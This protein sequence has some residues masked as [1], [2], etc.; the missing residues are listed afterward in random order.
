MTISLGILFGIVAMISWGVAD[1]FVAKAVRKSGVFKTFIWTQIIGLILFLVIFSLFFKFPILSFKALIL[2]LIAVFV[3]FIPLLA[4]YKG[5]QIGA[6]SIISPI[7]ASY[8]AIAVILSL[9]FLNETLTVLQAIGVSL[10]ILGAVL[11]SFKFHDLT[12]LRL[13]NF[14]TAV[15]Y[16]IIAMLGWGVLV[17]LIGILVSEL[18]WFFPVFL[19]KMLIV[20]YAL[21]YA[22]AAKKNISF[23]KNAALFV[24][25]IGFLES[26][27][28]LAFG[29][30]VSLEYTAIIAPVSSVYPA[31]TIILAQIFLKEILD[32]NQKIGIAFVLLGL[33]LLAI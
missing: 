19:V 21:S 30:G 27:G 1:F 5:L 20:L 14:A 16:A 13:K 28:F 11:T 9:I 10:A 32:I 22:G 24:I 31:I 6:V 4:Y 15:K 7:A 12:K 2:I 33:V 3:G 25:L 26:I 23:P 29:A 8:A 17:V 18:G